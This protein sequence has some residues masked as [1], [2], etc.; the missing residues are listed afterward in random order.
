MKRHNLKIIVMVSCA[1]SYVN[2]KKH[3]AFDIFLK[4]MGLVALVAEL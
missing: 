1:L 4:H 2:L 3:T